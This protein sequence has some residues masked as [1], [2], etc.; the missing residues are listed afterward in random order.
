VKSPPWFKPWRIGRVLA[1]GALSCAAVA[2]PIS[3]S[4]PSMSQAVES[5]WQRSL[6]AS[7]ASGQQRRAQAE[8]GAADAWL[9]A[10]PSLELQQREGR[11]HSDGRET[12]LGL[13]L[14]LWRPGQRAR[15]GQAAQAE[16][17]WGTAAEQAARWRLA[18]AVREAAAG[19]RAQASEAGLTGLRQGLLQR[20]SDDVARR[21]QAGEL[22][23]ADALAAR[24]DLV[25]AEAQ[26]AEARQRLQA[27]RSRW[28]LLTGLAELPAAAA[29]PPATATPPLDEHPELR[30]ALQTLERA[31][32]RL[33]LVQA[34]RDAAPEL[35]LSWRQERPGQGAATQHSVALGLRMPFG[36]EAHSQPRLS[37]ALAEQ[38][39]AYA[40]VQRSRERL[41]VE[42]ELAR[43]QL[44]SGREQS[45]LGD[46]RAALLRER[47]GLITTS[48]KAGETAL[49]ELLRAVNA[50][51]QAET[52]AARQ[53]AALGLALA[54][55]QQAAGILP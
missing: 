12:E 10:A 2:Q 50:A 45:R 13:A 55:Y 16:I 11:R 18:G 7:E 4:V 23:P 21:V 6:E 39:L 32:Q 20:L 48:F 14:P 43:S 8:Q 29:E 9:A 30:L 5:A 22:A 40:L 31:R 41:G 36:G 28:Q 46:E 52:S 54:R 51:A 27:L 49:P 47:A 42:L 15:A 17:D 3:S 26:D 33:A 35:G 38:D 25:E 24:A 34:Q 19:V 44:L 1:A 37:A 53:Q